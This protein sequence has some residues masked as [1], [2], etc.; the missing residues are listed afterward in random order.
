MKKNFVLLI[1]FILFFSISCNEGLIPHNAF[2]HGKVFI[3]GG[4]NTWPSADS[5]VAVRPVAFIELPSGDLLTQITSGKA[6]YNSNSIPLFVDSTE[7]SLEIP[8]PPRDLKYICLAM[9]YSNSL[10][11]QKVIGIYTLTGDNTKPTEMF[12][13]A[14]IAYN[15]IINVDFS[16]LPPQPN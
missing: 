9:Q 15:I 14:G 3:K 2:I 12:I 6:F 8:N 16:N 13:E 1:L 11:S 7:F 4:K 5:C 10:L